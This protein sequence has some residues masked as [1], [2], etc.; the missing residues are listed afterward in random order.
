MSW[1]AQL[2]FIG[3][4]C[5][6]SGQADLQCV[7]QSLNNDPAL[8]QQTAPERTGEAIDVILTADAVIVWDVAS[9]RILYEKNPDKQ[10][11][12]ASL[13]KL[14]SMLA[15][16]A[17]LAPNTAVEIPTEA[18]RAQRLGAHIRLPVGEHATVSDLLAA[19]AI[20][21]ANDAM[22]TLAVASSGSEEAFARYAS[23]YA[24]DHL[25]V[26]N[27]RLANATGLSGGD[28]F[29]TARDIKTLLIAAHQDSLIGPSLSKPSEVLTT[30]EG[31]RR[32]Y[33]TTNDLLGTYLPIVV[34]KTG[35]TIEAGENLAVITRGESG[36]QIGAVVLGSS[37]R[38][39][40]MKILV[41][42][43]WRNYTWPS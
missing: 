25:G 40:D 35:Y 4:T 21:S 29:S 8:A 31:T 22:V 36:Q 32:A 41:E 28:Q 39:Q 19:S 33:E 10:R 37:Q 17:Q 5:L 34:G 20:A 6:L 3:A 11:P 16:R 30:V 23:Q 15:A 1:I 12:V 42:W 13:S 7:T 18:A 43:I 24:K 9:D 38:F 26:Y 27:T 14:L 2:V